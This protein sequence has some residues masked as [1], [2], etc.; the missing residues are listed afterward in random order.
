MSGL[1]A[2]VRALSESLNNLKTTSTPS[3]R[4]LHSNCESCHL[5]LEHTRL[6]YLEIVTAGRPRSVQEDQAKLPRPCFPWAGTPQ[7]FHEGS[8]LNSSCIVDRKIFHHLRTQ[9][10][11]G[12]EGLR[13]V[14]SWVTRAQPL[15]QAHRFYSQYFPG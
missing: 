13:V 1:W 12:L 4:R 7:S 6:L 10:P 14:A 5:H 15:M 9:G 11:L 8:H 3:T 2:Q